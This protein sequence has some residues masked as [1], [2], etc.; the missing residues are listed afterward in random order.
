MKRILTLILCAVMV[1]PIFGTQNISAQ[2]I[3]FAEDYE[4]AVSVL[5]HIGIVD[6]FNTENGGNAYNT[7]SR[8]KF[9][10]MVAKA[11]KL[12]N[13]SDTVYFSDVKTDHRA[14]AYIN[15]LVESNI[16][17]LA[18]DNLFNHDDIV[19][20]EQAVKMLVRAMGYGV[21][22]DGEGGFP[23]GY[24]KAANRLKLTDGRTVSGE[25][26]YSD[27]VILLFNAMNTGVLDTTSISQD[28]SGYAQSEDTILSIYWNIYEKEGRLTEYYGGSMDSKFVDKGEVYIGGT[29]YKL[30]D[31]INPKPYF[32]NYVEY[33][34]EEN[35]NEGTVIYIQNSDA[36]ND[37]AIIDTKQYISFSGDSNTITYYR[38]NSN[39]TTT[40][41]F[42]RNARIIFNGMPYEG[43]LKKLFADKF[44][45]KSHRGTIYLSSTGEQKNDL[46]VIEA[47]RAFVIGHADADNKI[48][49]KYNYSDVINLDKC[50]FVN[51]CDTD[52]NVIENNIAADNV[53]MAAVSEDK[54]NIS[55]IYYRTP[56]ANGEVSVIGN[57][58]KIVI[59]SKE[60][61]IDKS[62]L[63]TTPIPKAGSVCE[64]Y[65]DSF[66]YII[67]INESKNKSGLRLGYVM[68]YTRK[69][70]AFGEYTLMFK[71]LDQDNKIITTES[72]DTIIV[73]GIKRNST[74]I[75]KNPV[76][77]LPKVKAVGNGYAMEQQLI[78]YR[79]DSDNIIKEIDTTYETDKE[80]DSK[81]YTLTQYPDNVY[82][83]IIP[84][85]EKNRKQLRRV[86]QGGK[87][88][89]RLDSN[90]L[91]TEK[92]S[93]MFNVPLTDAEGYL[94]HEASWFKREGTYAK[95]QDYIFDENGQ[96]IKAD[97]SMYG[98]GY[99]TLSIVYSY[100]I[101]AYDCNKDE[102][103]A[104]GIVYHY[105]VAER[106]S[107]LQ[108]VTGFSD[109]LDSDGQ[110]TKYITLMSNSSEK[111]YPIEEGLL[112]V[113]D[114]AG[115]IDKIEEGDIVI[116]DRD[117]KSDRI[118]NLTKVYDVK[119]NKITPVPYGG[120]TAYENWASGGYVSSYIRYLEA[121]QLTKGKVLK[122]VGTVLYVDW[123][124][125][126]VYDEA[127]ETSGAGIVVYDSVN[128]K[129]GKKITLGS[130]ADINDYE[131]SGDEYSEVLCSFDY[132]T[133]INVFVYKNR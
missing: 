20:Y 36:Q 91:F 62:V 117:E 6:E 30:S 67:C 40:T 43:S 50:E 116:V 131:T 19:T 100:F 76:N 41:S 9:S 71:L 46:I 98:V 49:N 38:N 97:D 10:E 5:K 17:S 78:R 104:E 89:N 65:V 106:L 3:L 113:K 99:K 27:A 32:T 52:G 109:G 42:P 101:D 15:A 51:F 57:D 86:S 93:V 74:D 29:K 112:N 55:L 108:F 54:S 64:I 22:A 58:N 63:N 95:D 129:G 21:Y 73:D 69:D 11:L 125:D 28:S 87:I 102:P 44:D 107:T 7:V 126:F 31:K 124:D 2:E 121:R 84:G 111:S 39:S 103:S 94:M 110:Q 77:I 70:S 122:R 16:V 90:I 66:G 48:Y 119:T 60:Y 115:N 47:Y 23:Y 35:N 45:N 68:D 24:I 96:K 33:L 34:Y 8:A 127:V 12:K 14:Y 120:H 37:G 133:T 75:A 53:Y 81:G 72:G 132:G 118:Y 128:T 114:A 82:K 59:D 85:V 80:E 1:I 26:N 13:A 18:D 79:T 130:L 88:I 56:A 92:D 123:N 4:K 105:P 25:L 61:E 83:D